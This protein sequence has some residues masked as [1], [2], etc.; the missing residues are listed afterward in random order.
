MFREKILISPRIRN[1]N[2]L[3]WKNPLKKQLTEPFVIIEIL[4]HF[5]PFFS[6]YFFI[7]FIQQSWK[8]VWIYEYFQMF[9]PSRRTNYLVKIWTTS[10][11]I[12]LCK[13]SSYLSRARM[14]TH[15]FT[16]K[17]SQGVNF[18]MPTNVR[19]YNHWAKVDV[20]FLLRRRN[21]KMW[22][23]YRIRTNIKKL[24][25]ITLN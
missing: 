18:H 23:S 5:C 11:Q 9:I 12:F 19:L 1:H 6:S 8:S 10:K 2:L 24:W 16:Y 22:F 25:L 15:Y 7:N 20:I 17:K 13:I 4:S 21:R 3:F 14:F